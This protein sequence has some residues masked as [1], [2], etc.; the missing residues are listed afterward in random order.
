MHALRVGVAH[1]GSARAR[2]QRGSVLQAVGGPS[3]LSRGVRARDGWAGP[4]G[5]AAI[6]YAGWALLLASAAGVS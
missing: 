1:V 3:V 5:V 4:L 2:V 6:L